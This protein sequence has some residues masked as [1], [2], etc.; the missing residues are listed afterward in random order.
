[1]MDLMGQLSWLLLMAFVVGGLV[2][3]TTAGRKKA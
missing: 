1:M 3:W 2:G